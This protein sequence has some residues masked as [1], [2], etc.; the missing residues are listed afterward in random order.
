MPD[1]GFTFTVTD[2]GRFLGKSPVTLRG[3]EAQG[4]LT[5]PRAPGGD[6]KMDLGHV[7]EVAR[8]GFSLGRISEVRLNLILAAMTLLELLEKRKT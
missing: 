4:L 5:L 8:V 7:R 6:R 1:D 3:W 2:L